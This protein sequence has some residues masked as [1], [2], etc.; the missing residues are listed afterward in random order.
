MTKKIAIVTGALRGLGLAT[1]TALADHEYQVIVTGR[2]SEKGKKTV[3]EMNSLGQEAS[4]FF[5]D[6]SDPISIE[7]FANEI[8][9]TFKSVDVLINNAGIFVDSESDLTEISALAASLLKSISNNAVGPY[10]LAHRL[11]PLLKKS[12]AGRIVNVSSGMGQLSEMDGGY[13]G[14][15]LSKTALNAV[16]R[17]LHSEAE[18]SRVLVNSICPG[19]VKTDMGGPEAERSI[20]EGIDTIVWAAT[21][22]AGAPSGQ[23]FRDRKVIDW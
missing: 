4:F 11:M 23:F 20:A 6:A 9:K 21:L 10:L 3:S 22:P 15:R 18:G 2:H 16:T 12:T 8:E 13:V 5:L 1:A 14:Y 19:W 7:T 17:I